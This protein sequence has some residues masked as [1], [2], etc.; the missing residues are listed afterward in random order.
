M[1]LLGKSHATHSRNFN[2]SS[3]STSKLKVKLGGEKERSRE[4]E[5]GFALKFEKPGGGKHSCMNYCI[6]PAGSTNSRGELAAG[7]YLTFS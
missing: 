2:C 5:G 4:K 1:S 6:Q 3:R 7:C